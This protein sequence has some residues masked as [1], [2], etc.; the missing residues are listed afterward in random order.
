MANTYSQIYIQIVFSVKERKNLLQPPWRQEVYKYIAGII[1]NKGHKSI[2]VNGMADH[3]HILIGLKP[4]AALSDLVR[5]IKNNTTNYINQNQWVQ[6]KFAW[7]E[8][9]GAFSYGHSQLEDVYQYI[10]HQE[11]HHQKHTFKDEYLRLLQ[12]FQI[13]YEEPYLFEWIDS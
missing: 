5:G 13:P 9:Y 11:E 1:K 10:L 12:K 2:I 8:G 4:S 6:G 7:Q 3:V